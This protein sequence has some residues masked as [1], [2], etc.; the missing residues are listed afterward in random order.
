MAR[1]P[2]ESGRP[3]DITED[4]P[5]KSGQLAIPGSN[6][7]L[8]RLYA[9]LHRRMAHHMDEAE[10]EGAAEGHGGPMQVSP[11]GSSHRGGDQL[12]NVS[13]RS[14]FSPP[15]S[16]PGSAAL[17]YRLPP[18]SSFSPVQDRALSSSGGA[19]FSAT[20]PAPAVDAS[21]TWSDPP[22]KLT[23]VKL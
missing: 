21:P 4:A 20:A 17:P 23:W 2:P 12:A 19:G 18:S 13:A 22:E 1:P 8:E 11:G 16:A 6:P 10:R 7:E 15:A 9:E 3:G 14:A 5:A